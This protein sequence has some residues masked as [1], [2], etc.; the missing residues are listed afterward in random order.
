MRIW[1]AIVLALLAIGAGAAGA[2]GTK[3]WHRCEQLLSL[4]DGRGHVIFPYVSDISE[5]S[6]YRAVVTGFRQTGPKSAIADTRGDWSIIQGDC[7]QSGVV[8]NCK[9]WG[10][11]THIRYR[12]SD[13]GRS[14]RPVSF[15][16]TVKRWEGPGP[17]PP[18]M[19]GSVE[20]DP[21]LTP[22]DWT[23]A[24]RHVLAVGIVPGLGSWCAPPDAWTVPDSLWP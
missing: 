21:P 4:C 11:M 7:G 8:Q 15:H 10:G 23:H 6:G 17:D 16:R 13:R 18:I 12:T 2:A 14:W 5:S 1:L 24:H 19:T 3:G 20:D 22:C 9:E